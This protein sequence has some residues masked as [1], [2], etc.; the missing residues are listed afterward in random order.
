LLLE[1]EEDA[2]GCGAYTP[3]G[4]GFWVC[5]GVWK[6]EDGEAYASTA[7]IACIG[8]ATDPGPASGAG[9]VDGGELENR[10]SCSA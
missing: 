1:E 4:A 3:F 9:V 7:P 8:A 5:V 6:C 2:D 10:M